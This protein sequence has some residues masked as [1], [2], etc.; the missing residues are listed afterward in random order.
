MRAI[1]FR[2]AKEAELKFKP[3]LCAPKPTLPAGYPM[4]PC[5][6]FSLPCKSLYQ[7]GLASGLESPWRW[8]WAA[9]TAC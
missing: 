3:D 7:A 8:D 6:G 5:D 9:E 2:A 4:S 1:I